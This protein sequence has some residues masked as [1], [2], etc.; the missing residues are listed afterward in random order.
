LAHF[1]PSLRP[2]LRCWWRRGYASWEQQREW[3]IAPWVRPEFSRQFGLWDRAVAR[4]RR[5]SHRCR[6]LALSVALDMLDLS[7]GDATRWEL[8][9]PRGLMTAHPYFDPRL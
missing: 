9:V 1:L 2:G 7:V 4:L 5:S 6:P 3:T 8:G